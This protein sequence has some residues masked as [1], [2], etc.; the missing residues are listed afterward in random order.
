MF[1]CSLSFLLYFLV[2]CTISLSLHVA[3]KTLFSVYGGLTFKQ[4]K[5]TLNQN[6]ADDHRIF[7]FFLFC[8]LFFSPLFISTVDARENYCESG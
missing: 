4:A 2:Y 8:F 3:M 1:T 6:V 5:S 7:C